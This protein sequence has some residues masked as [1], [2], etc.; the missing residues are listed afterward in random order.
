MSSF[1]TARFFHKQVIVFRRPPSSAGVDRP[2]CAKWMERA[3]KKYSWIARTLL[4]VAGRF[5]AVM[6]LV[7]TSS[8]PPIELR[9]AHEVRESTGDAFLSN[10]TCEDES[11]D[12]GLILA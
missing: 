2:L 11:D 5:A 4:R 6:D 9:A 12:G 7:A 3:F 1:L 8:G 10:E